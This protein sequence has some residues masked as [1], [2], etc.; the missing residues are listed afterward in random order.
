MGIYR[1]FTKHEQQSGQ[2]AP[3]APDASIAVKLYTPLSLCF[4]SF[5]YMFSFTGAEILIKKV[6]TAR[7]HTTFLTTHTLNSVKRNNG[8][9][10]YTL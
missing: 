10:K 2:D 4:G 9:W 8:L 3:G 7:K 5:D 6:E 1:F